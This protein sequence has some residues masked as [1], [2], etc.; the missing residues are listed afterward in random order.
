MLQYYFVLQCY[1]LKTSQQE[2]ERSK[3]DLGAL[4]TKMKW[5]QNNLKVEIEHRKVS[6]YHIK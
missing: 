1:E 2:L 6:I 4:E 3:A 5:S